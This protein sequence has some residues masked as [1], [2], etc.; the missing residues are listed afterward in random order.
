MPIPRCPHLNLHTAELSLF[1][2]TIKRDP[3][4]NK[5]QIY[6]ICLL[7]A[8]TGMRTGSYTKSETSP[9]KMVPETKALRNEYGPLRFEHTQFFLT[10]DGI[11]VSL[12]FIH[13]KGNVRSGMA[14]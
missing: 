7:A 6:V 8:M 5:L 9:R 4:A 11:G 13:C 10:Q 14:R 2:E 12:K 3:I 1:Y